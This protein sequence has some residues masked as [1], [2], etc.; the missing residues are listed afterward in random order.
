MPPLVG[1]TLRWVRGDSTG[2]TGRRSVREEGEVQSC[3]VGGGEEVHP[4]GPSR[5]GRARL[6]GFSSRKGPGAVGGPASVLGPLHT[7]IP[8]ARAQRAPQSGSEA[9]I[10][11]GTSRSHP[12]SPL[13]PAQSCAF[14]APGTPV[15]LNLICCLFSTTRVPLLSLRPP[16]SWEGGGAM[17][18]PPFTPCRGPSPPE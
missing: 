16:A 3:T 6:S 9:G 10:D 13:A 4:L 5:H 1:L 11:C 17:Q 18:T 12:A 15:P 14:P 7:A 2:R 8:I